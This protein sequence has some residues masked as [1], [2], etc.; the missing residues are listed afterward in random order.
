MMFCPASD[1]ATWTCDRYRVPLPPPASR[2]PPELQHPG[3]ED[4]LSEDRPKA[5]S[6][7]R[8][9]TWSSAPGLQESLAHSQ[10]RLPHQFLRFPELPSIRGQTCGRCMFFCPLLPAALPAIVLPA[11][12]STL[13]PGHSEKWRMADRGDASRRI[14]LQVVLRSSIRLLVRTFASSSVSTESS[15]E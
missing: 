8:T 14:R 4:A 9:S 3:I 11:E 5:A 6:H 12:S 15:G 10:A 7:G 13:P 2:R 1:R